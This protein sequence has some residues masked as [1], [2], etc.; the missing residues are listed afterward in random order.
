[1]YVIVEKSRGRLY[2]YREDAAH[3]RAAEKERQDLKKLPPKVLDAECDLSDLP[4][5]SYIVFKLAVRKPTKNPKK[6]K[7]SSA[8]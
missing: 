4:N 2:A 5:N 6:K 8:S 3:F 1:M 7:K